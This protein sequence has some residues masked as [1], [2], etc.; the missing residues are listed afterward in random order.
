MSRLDYW[1]QDAGIDVTELFPADVT[2]RQA[3]QVATFTWDT[4]LVA[5]KRLA[6]AGHMF[7]NPISGCREAND[8]LWPLLLSFGALPVT[9]T[10][11]MAIESDATLAAIEFVVE[12]SQSMPR[13][14]YRWTDG[15]D[16]LW[17]LAGN[18]AAIVESPNIWVRA[19]REQPAVA[20]H[21][22]HHD[23]P[24]GPHGRFR[25]VDFSTYGI[26]RFSSHK[27]AAKDLLRHL[28]QHEQQWK[29]LYAGQGVDRPALKAFAAHPVWTEAVSPPGGLYNYLPRGDEQLIPAGW[30][31]PPAIAVQ[32]VKRYVIPAM[33]ARAATGKMTPK[34]AM[35]WAARAIEAAVKGESQ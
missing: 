21:L 5:C 19:T 34:E 25:S 14:I 35:Q 3:S 20:A 32:V 2:Q 12:L 17:L 18:G 22:W 15:S 31:A 1:Q 28:L 27:Q 10:G 24:A 8:W 11:D 23:V 4:F 33:M 26:W 29:L 6:A 13:E 7:G 9:A 30:P 16:D